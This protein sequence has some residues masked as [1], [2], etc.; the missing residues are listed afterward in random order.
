MAKTSMITK[1]AKLKRK[2]AHRRAN[3][4]APLPKST[5]RVR[6]RCRKCGRPRGYMRFFDMCRICFREKARRG[7][8]MGVRKSSW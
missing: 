6:N 4:H 8:I 5:V 7:E 1:A 2:V 3:G